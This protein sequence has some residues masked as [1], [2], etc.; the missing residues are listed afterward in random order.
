MDQIKYRDGYK[1]QLHVDY[2]VKTAVMPGHNVKTPYIH[3]TADGLLTIKAGYCWDGPSGPTVDT[4][5][6]MRGSLVHDA[7]YQLMCERNLDV[8]WRETVDKE[9]IRMCKEDG[10]SGI[11]R[12]WVYRGVRL[13]GE[14]AAEWQEV[15]VCTAP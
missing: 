12:W 3:L 14:N 9:L 5:N 8:G 15:K 7:C 4:K 13:A 6:F 11:R 10:M 1:Y 2:T